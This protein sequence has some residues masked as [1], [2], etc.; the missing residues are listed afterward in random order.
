MGNLGT[1]TAALGTAMR[2]AAG[3]EPYTEFPSAWLGGSKLKYQY[4]S[5]FN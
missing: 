4:L 1:N 2:I 5:S 3:E